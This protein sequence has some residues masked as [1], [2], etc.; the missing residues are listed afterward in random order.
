MR[1][2]TAGPVACVNGGEV[3]ALARTGQVLV[4]STVKDLVAGSDIESVEHGEHTQ[5]RHWNLEALR[6]QRIGASSTERVVPKQVGRRP[7]AHVIG[8]TGIDAV[9]EPVRFVGRDVADT[10]AHTRQLR[11]VGYAREFVQTRSPD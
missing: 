2:L 7:P 10:S 5:R 8:P 1:G 9:V 4:S 11:T 6:R 3:R